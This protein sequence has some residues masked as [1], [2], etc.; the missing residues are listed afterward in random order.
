[1]DSEKF[2]RQLDEYFEKN[3]IEAAGKYLEESL[4]IVRKEGNVSLEIAILNEMMGYYRST[5]QEEKGI[6]SVEEGVYL[7]RDSGLEGHPEVAKMWINMGTTLC[8]F[9]RVEEAEICYKNAEMFFGESAYGALNMAGL[10]NNTAAVYVKTGRFEEAAKRYDKALEILDT[11]QEESEF[12]E[13]LAF[14]RIVT[15]L[16]MIV[17]NRVKMESENHPDNS[18][19][20][21]EIQKKVSL[22]KEALSSSKFQNTSSF[23][24]AV[25][26]SVHCFENLGDEEN[27]AWVKALENQ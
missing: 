9:E 26:K 12:W 4:E 17:M 14:N 23:P 11:L 3:E 24:Y 15:W 16:N 8:H 6:R 21:K 25:K 19:T 2:F 20:E 10:Y 18:E 22:V 27:A 1:M 7:I 5:N 13:D